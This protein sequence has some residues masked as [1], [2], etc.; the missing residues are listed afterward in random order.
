MHR[1]TR[2]LLATLLT[3]RVSAAEPQVINIKTVHAKMLYDVTD[4]TVRPGAEVRIVFE[5]MDDM[6]HNWVLFQPGVATPQKK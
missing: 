4:F 3:V 5:N 2:L 1:T 6:P